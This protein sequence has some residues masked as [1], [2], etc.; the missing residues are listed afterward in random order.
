MK[1]YINIIYMIPN[2]FN[3]KE[4][5]YLNKDLRY[6]TSEDEAKQH[7][8]LYGKNENR[9]YKDI[10]PDDFNIFNYKLLNSDLNN[11]DNYEL[12]LH[13]IKYGKDENRK[14][15]INKKYI[16]FINHD[17]SLTGAPIFL[18][19]YVVYLEEKNLIDN[20]I[21]FDVY[22]NEKLYS[23]Y[24]NRLKNDPIYHY[25]DNDILIKYIR[26]YDPIFIYS[27][28]LSII[29]R[30]LD[31]YKE[32]KSK[33]IFHF[34]ETLDF[35]NSQNS[36]GSYDDYI[37]N[38]IYVVSEKILN[39]YKDYFNFSNIRVFP[40]FIS[41]TKLNKLER[42]SNEN[43]DINIL[44][45]IT[46][47]MIG[48]RIF[49]KGYDIFINI[50]KELPEYNF[51]WIGDNFD[52]KLEKYSNI[53][54][55]EHTDNPFKYFKYI[56]YLLLTS[57]EDPCPYVILESLYFGISC[58]VLDKNIKYDHNIDNYHIIKNHN[59]DYNKIVEY[60]KNMKLEKL[61]YNHL[62]EY[63]IENFSRPKINLI[64]HTS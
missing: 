50:A 24:K 28:S 26:N 54:Q 48:T 18:Y 33:I 36:N 58:I 3:Y 51:I 32:F 25:N 63:I 38:K 27:N 53:Y 15:L 1:I 52:N 44:N 14:Y 59:N 34:H 7:Y 39:D 11:L 19:D 49:R 8:L 2:D 5:I 4:Y 10:L 16:F 6:I 29:T 21:I 12:V 45:N 41:S 56:D 30:N 37:D 22:R 17:P 64:T 55:I 62:R 46:F 57:R 35:L 20:I 31:L 47:C 60:I 40:P 9:I 43:I 61:R 13:Y 42:L 23:I